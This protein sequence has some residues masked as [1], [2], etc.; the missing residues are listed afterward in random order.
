MSCYMRHMTWLLEALELPDDKANRKLVDNALREELELPSE[1]HCPEVWASVKT[2]TEDE[3]GQ[4]ATG[5]RA[6]LGC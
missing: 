6:R 3:R 1:Y 5:L 2:L 4:L